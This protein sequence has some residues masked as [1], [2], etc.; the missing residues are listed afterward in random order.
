MVERSIVS[1]PP[2]SVIS[3]WAHGPSLKT[4]VSDPPPPV[5]DGRLSLVNDGQG[6]TQVWF[7]ANGL[8]IG[9]GGTWEV[10]QLDHVSSS[11]LH[12]SGAFITG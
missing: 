4:K 10:A 7:N 11:S 8:P 9:S 1:C 6:D 12:V 2:K 3:A 5:A